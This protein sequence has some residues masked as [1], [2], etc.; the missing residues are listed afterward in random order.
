M[1]S[2]GLPRIADGHGLDRN[3][4]VRGS[5]EDRGEKTKK[6]PRG[7]AGESATAEAPGS[8]QR[9][10]HSG[11]RNAKDVRGGFVHGSFH[12]SYSFCE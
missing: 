11:Q 4:A 1:E 9:R 8:A 6:E 3:R 12:F 7:H 2:F 10:Q 5:Q